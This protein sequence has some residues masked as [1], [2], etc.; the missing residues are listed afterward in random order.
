MSVHDKKG[1][2]RAN[3][4]ALMERFDICVE[5]LNALIPKAKTMFS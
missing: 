5:V 2:M 3:P 4:K 1:Y